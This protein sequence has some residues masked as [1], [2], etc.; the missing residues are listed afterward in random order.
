[1]HGIHFYSYRDCFAGIYI[2]NRSDLIISYV[3]PPVDYLVIKKWDMAALEYQY[4]FLT[5]EVILRQ[6]LLNFSRVD[7]ILLL[8]M[9]PALRKFIICLLWRIPKFVDLLEQSQ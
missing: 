5:L 8:D 4:E 7:D 1:M 2:V 9:V 3:F 6:W